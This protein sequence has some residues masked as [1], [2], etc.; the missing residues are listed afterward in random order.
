MKKTKKSI[1]FLA[2]IFCILIT[3]TGCGN[4]KIIATK[5]STIS[6]M[7]YDERIEVTFKGNKADKIVWELTFSEEKIAEAYVSSFK[8]MYDIDIKQDGNKAI[9]TLNS[10]SFSKIVGDEKFDSSY[11]RMKEDFESEGYTVE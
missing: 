4:K 5:T 8:N 1:L 2:I 11:K 3:L 9:M 6:N 10:D 7:N